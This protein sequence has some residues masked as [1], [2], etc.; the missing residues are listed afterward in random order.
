MEIVLERKWKKPNYTIGMLSIDGKRF[1]E[2][3]EDA[4]RGLKDSMSIGQIKSLKKSHITAIP[5]GVYEVN[6]N[7]VSPKFGSRSFYKEVC[8][9]KVPRLLN[10]KGFDG[11]LIH[12][13]NKAED[14]DGCILVGQN[15][16]VGQ[17]INSQATFRELYKILSN[18]KDKI[19]IKII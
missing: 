19:T 1:C 14:T 5:T 6:L 12:A 10:V 9:G 16:V 17:V 4:D 8:K 7:T 18:S 2:T 3:L 11:I 13:G 15:K